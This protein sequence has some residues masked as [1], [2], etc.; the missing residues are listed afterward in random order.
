MK[1]IIMGCQTYT[2][3][4]S[5][6]KY[7]QKLDHIMDVVSKVGFYRIGPKVCMLGPF[8]KQ[9]QK[10]ADELESN[11]LKL[12]ALCLVCDWLGDQESEPERKEADRIIG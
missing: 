8:K 2:W 10:L 4:M 6:Q 3:Q 1:K 5:Y 7:S 9:S 11:N 12:G